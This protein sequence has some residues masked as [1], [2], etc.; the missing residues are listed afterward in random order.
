[1][2]YK[3]RQFVFH[4]TYEMASLVEA[5]VSNSS[6]FIEIDWQNPD[7]L[8][9]VSEFTKTCLLHYYIYAMISVEERNDF[10]DNDDIYEDSEEERERIE[11]ALQAYN[12]DHLPYSEFRSTNAGD[13]TEDFPFRQ[14]FHSQEEKFDLLW[15]KMT[16]EVFHLLFANRAFLLQFNQS[17]A[18]YLKSGI[19]NIPTEYLDEKGVIKRQPYFPTWVKKAVYYRDQGRCVLCQS[20]LSGLLS[21]DQHIHYD[22]IV[23]LNLWGTNDP[24]NIQLLC[25]DCN[26]KKSGTSAKTATRYHSWWNY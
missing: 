24:S 11:A 14:W 10:S 18:N 1:M 2:R 13:T 15:E 5:C 20:D 6:S 9:C 8:K 7:V 3:T 22:H 25:E 12:I 4:R 17:L 16:D 21:T 23:P 19:I 26:L